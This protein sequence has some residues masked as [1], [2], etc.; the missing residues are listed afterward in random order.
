M[1]DR[2]PPGD[3][4][5]LGHDRQIQIVSGFGPMSD[6]TGFDYSSFPVLTTE[7]LTLRELLLSDAADVLVFR[8]D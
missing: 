6:S 2:D 4:K 8:G 5:R 3:I 1:F 7:R